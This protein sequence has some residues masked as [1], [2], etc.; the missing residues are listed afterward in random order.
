MV[1]SN[2]TFRQQFRRQICTKRQFFHFVQNIS[3]SHHWSLASL[4]WHCCKPVWS[5]QSK[6]NSPHLVS[7]N[8]QCPHIFF[9]LKMWYNKHTAKPQNYVDKTCVEL[10]IFVAPNH[11]GKLPLFTENGKSLARLAGPMLSLSLL[12]CASLFF[13]GP[14]IISWTYQTCSNF[15]STSCRQYQLQFKGFV[16]G[17]VYKTD[18]SG[19][20]KMFGLGL[21]L[22]ITRSPGW[23][24]AH[25][26]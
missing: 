1:T 8:F 3:K 9:L 2:N 11:S 16:T 26:I 4:V 15:S 21:I 20:Q 13:N 18:L 14:R 23:G 25:R 22:W 7:L 5:P 10:C 17:L 12:I 6:G 19:L 24:H